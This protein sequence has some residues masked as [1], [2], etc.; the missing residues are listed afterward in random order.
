MTAFNDFS[1]GIA[2]VRTLLSLCTGEAK[3][4][5]VL[6]DARSNAICRAATVLLVSHF[7]SFLKT[8]AEEFI[9]AIATGDVTSRAIPVGVKELHS[10]PRME[11]ILATNNTNQRVVLFGK[12]AEYNCL[13]VA[14]AKPPPRLL[15]SEILRRV[16]TNPGSQ[17]IDTLYTL[18]G[19][20]TPVCDGDIDVEL[21][22][23]GAPAPVNIRL[24]LRT[25]VECRNDIA[26]GD[27]TRIPTSEDVDRYIRQLEA[28]ARR[29]EARAT[30]LA[31]NVRR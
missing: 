12:I 27:V 28:F 7:E 10:I 21:A 22:D 26:H 23:Q 14:D 30:L 8:T 17:I 24:M 18:M 19:A 13:W 25:V 2:E 11:E 20:S 29:L 3:H 9:D 1:S 5:D 4:E 16:V 6:G 15:K 31:E